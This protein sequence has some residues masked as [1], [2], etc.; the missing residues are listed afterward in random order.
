M[1]GVLVCGRAGGEAAREYIA[2]SIVD[3]GRVGYADLLVLGVI[4]DCCCDAAERGV[5]D[6]SDA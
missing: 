3:S 1:D 4:R 2:S 5:H 6:R